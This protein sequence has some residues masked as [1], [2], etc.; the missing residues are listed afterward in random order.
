MI[1]REA[2]ARA[3]HAYAEA[4]Y[5][6]P[7]G[8]EVEIAITAYLEIVRAKGLALMPR[9]PTPEMVFASA[10]DIEQRGTCMG[11]WRAMYDAALEPGEMK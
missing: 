11:I 10:L 1:D 3:R 5:T 2:L 8:T 9:E 6:R 4:V 7:V